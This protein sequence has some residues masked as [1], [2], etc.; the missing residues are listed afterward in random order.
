MRQGEILGVAKV[1]TCGLVMGSR[2][3]INKT[4]KGEKC[5]VWYCTC[6]PSR[7]ELQVR[8]QIGSRSEC[9]AVQRKISYLSRRDLPC[10]RLH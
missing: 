10:S 2:G 1:P 8:Y 6:I 5:G 4:E 7:T 3:K 9:N